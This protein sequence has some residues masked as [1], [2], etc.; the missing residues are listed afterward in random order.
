MCNVGMVEMKNLTNEYVD[1]EYH[2]VFGHHKD[3]FVHG[4][5]IATITLSTNLKHLI[6]KVD[7]KL[8]NFE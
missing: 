2:K 8:D 7:C 1:L 3:S 6:D 4:C 5:L